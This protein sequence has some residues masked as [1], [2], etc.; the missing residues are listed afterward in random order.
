MKSIMSYYR[1]RQE[2]IKEKNDPDTYRKDFR[3]SAPLFA[4][5]VI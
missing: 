4:P 3:R 5:T 2:K 1:K